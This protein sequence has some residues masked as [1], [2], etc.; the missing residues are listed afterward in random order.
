M[1]RAL[2]AFI[3]FLLITNLYLAQEPK[4]EEKKERGALTPKEELKTFQLAEGFQ[5]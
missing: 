2:I 3:P 1:R 4:P 5:I